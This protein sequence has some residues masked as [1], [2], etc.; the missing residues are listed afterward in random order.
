[1]N[2]DEKLISNG[3]IGSLIDKLSRMEIMLKKIKISCIYLFL[4]YLVM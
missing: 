2:G 1:M 3:N 4:N